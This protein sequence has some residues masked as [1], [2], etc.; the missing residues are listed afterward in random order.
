M[1]SRLS[2]AFLLLFAFI[3]TLIISLQPTA[4]VGA[5]TGSTPDLTDANI[6]FFEDNFGVSRFE[7]TDEGLSRFAALLELLGAQLFTLESRK[8][9]PNDADL[10]V[11]SAPSSLDEGQLARLWTY[12]GDGGRVFL[13]GD[14]FDARGFNRPG[15][16]TD[17]TFE[18]F[19]TDFGLTGAAEVL[20]TPGQQTT[21]TFQE[22]DTRNLPTGNSFQATAPTLD[23]QFLT[24]NI[25]PQHPIMAPIA[26]I[27][28]S[29]GDEAATA[30]NLN[31]FF[32]DGSYRYIVDGGLSPDVVVPLIF[33]EG[34]V[35]YGESNYDGFVASGGFSEYNIGQDSPRSQLIVAVAYENANSDARIVF[36][37]DVDFLRNGGG[38]AVSPPYS[39]SFVYPANV[40]FAVQ[41]VSWLLETAVDP[42]TLPTPAPTATA[43]ITP[44]PVPTA[45]PEPATDGS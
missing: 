34:E 24:R 15:Y 36:L 43:T 3:S 18:L 16:L 45:T 29:A 31:S 8:A 28:S 20:V 26:D 11:V 38:F 25:N 7:R 33:T 23:L 39:G 5:Q 30:N 27:I 6:Y 1:R 2:V 19:N 37:P 14:P 41:A 35:V 17:G 44:T 10:L 12:I 21:G 9:I 40:Q 13:V 4:T 22:L 32:F 42:L